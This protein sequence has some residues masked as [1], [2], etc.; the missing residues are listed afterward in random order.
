MTAL[1]TRKTL[2]LSDPKFSELTQVILQSYPNACVLW[3]ESV[4][5]YDVE[6]RF[7][8]RVRTLTEQMK[9]PTIKQLYHGTRHTSIQ[10]ICDNGWLISYNKRAAFGTGSYFATQASYSIAFTDVVAKS[11][12]DDAGVS[13]MFVADVVVGTVGLR[14]TDASDTFVDSLARPT[15]YVARHNDDAVPRYVIAFDKA[16]R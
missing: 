13:Y 1:S 6:A 8:E 16:A 9:E 10:S 4:A 11:H 12:V 14:H 3:I 2:K 15:M 7:R 5:S